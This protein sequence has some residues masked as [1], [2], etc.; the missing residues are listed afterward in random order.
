[1]ILGSPGAGKTTLGKVIAKQLDMTMIDI[2]AYI[3][4]FETEIPYTVMYSK[5][6]KIARLKKAVASA[7]EFVMAGSMNSFHEQFDHLFIMAVYLTAD[8]NIRVERVHQRELEEFGNRILP[9]GDMYESHQSFL[10]D[11]MNYD[12]ETCAC[13]YQQH[14]LWLSQLR[15][16]ILR[17]DGG[18]DLETNAAAMIAL[19]HKCQESA[20]KD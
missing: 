16:P 18:N 6:E 11:V 4:N 12:S 17:L 9:G 7:N 3:W 8:T 1:M 10:A 15:C 2:D 19:F 13:N 20:D 5:E 14:E